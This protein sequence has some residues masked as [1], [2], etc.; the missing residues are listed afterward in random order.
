MQTL[1]NL[2]GS[3]LK[4][5]IQFEELYPIPDQLRKLYQK[6]TLLELQPRSYSE[7]IRTILSA[8]LDRYERFYIIVDGLDEYPSRDRM[9]LLN[10]LKSLQ[11]RKLSLVV[12]SRPISG[13]P[14]VPGYFKCDRCETTDLKIYYRCKICYKGDYDLCQDCKRKGLSCLD[15][16]HNLSEPYRQVEVDVIIPN[17][18]IERYV[19]WEIGVSS[20]DNDGASRDER[21]NPEPLDTTPFQDL[22]R[23]NPDQP[24]RIV[25]QVVEKAS[26]RFLFAR[27]HIDALKMV[28]NLRQLQKTLKNFPDNLESIYQ[29]AMQRIHTQENNLMTLG[30]KILG[31]V[32]CA[33]RTLS[34]KEL[35]HALSVEASGN[36]EV[37]SEG[38]I[39][40]GIEPRKRI[41]D[42]TCGLVTI[43]NEGHEVRLV[44]RSL[45]D[46]LKLEENRAKWFPRADSE[47]AQA[48]IT[49]LTLVVPSKP[50]PDAYFNSKKVEFPFLQYVSQYWGDHVRDASSE[51]DVQ[52]AA[53]Q[54]INSP[55]HLAACMQAAWVTDTGGHDSW[56]IRERVDR[57]HVCAW[58]GLS[59][60][61]SAL[62]PEPRHVDVTESK[63]GQTP[64]MYAC[65]KGHV[66]TTSKLLD[67]GA[68]LGRVSTRGRTPMFEA[69]AGNHD[70]IV[71][72]LVDRRPSSLDINATHNKEYNRTALI[73]TANL[74]RYQ[75]AEV[76][77]QH[78]DIDVNVQDSFGMTAIAAASRAGCTRIVELLLIRPET[79]VDIVDF[80]AGR[81]ALRCAAER[82]FADVVELLLRN[83]AQPNLVDRQGGTAMLRAVYR[84]C[85]EALMA[86]I[87]FG[88]DLHCV[89]EDSQSLLHSA[90]RNGHFEIA[91]LLVE[92]GISPQV[93]DKDDLTPLHDASRCGET[94]VIHTLLDLGA[95]KTRKDNFGR[96]PH[97]VAW[98]YGQSEIMDILGN[99]LESQPDG[100]SH[101]LRE[102]KDLPLWSLARLGRTD[103]LT[104]AIKTRKQDLL[105]TEPG[106]DNTALH[107]AIQ[108][109]NADILEILLETHTI[110]I[111][112]PNHYHRTP[113]H[114]ASLLGHLSAVQLLISHGAN[115]NLQD[116]WNSTAL[117]LAQSNRH[118][119]IMTALVEAKATI[120]TQKIDVQKLFFF[121][122]EQGN[123]K[124]AKIL[125]ENGADRSTQNQ[126]GVRAMQIAEAGKDMEMVFLLRSSR[127]VRFDMS[128]VGEKDEEV[129]EYQGLGLGKVESGSSHSVPFRPLPMLEGAEMDSPPP[130]VYTPF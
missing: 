29:Q 75:M 98:Q 60:A 66:D 99:N 46:F 36:D 41:L 37:T 65:R 107:C 23:D 77:L 112:Q 105:I 16:S 24:E 42:C 130:P 127:T 129:V 12:T 18:D 101:N 35:Q 9:T 111:D 90:S 100:I 110:P 120:D 124:A 64:L 116:R 79:K 51:P 96:T 22:C 32:T 68:S 19:R 122:V 13:E 44:H 61:I 72:L 15:A 93:R 119:P 3:L 38:D 21:S 82:N 67:L 26:G 106:S 74:G 128:A 85:Q 59:F 113:L 55:Q 78:P 83:G 70:K 30:C 102:E 54:I 50:K 89:D 57:L 63:Y 28:S 27:L 76:L 33:R 34:L 95:D 71:K 40:L 91:R 20:E 73:L 103:V 2:F 6:A 58:Y 114:L 123:V 86:M 118:I 94:K 17:E 108:A 84:G 48:C 104:D 8:E 49:Y 80:D 109:N 52:A 43:D 7:E 117:I 53:L 11:A 56:D 87:D 1:P 14:R 45:E 126:D 88:V 25:S 97:D 81:S 115:L 125:L 92:N 5:L 69:I 39:H 62:E 4:Q 10:K 47:I 121:V 31:L